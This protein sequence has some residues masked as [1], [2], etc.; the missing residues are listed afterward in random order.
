MIKVQFRNIEII[1]FH[2][3][4]PQEKPALAKLKKLFLEYSLFII[5]QREK[6]GFNMIYAIMKIKYMVMKL[7][8][9][10]LNASNRRKKHK[11]A[12]NEEKSSF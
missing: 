3:K 10:K 1:M 4:L 12:V 6:K 9:G 2:S 11:W 8:A 7:A 5:F